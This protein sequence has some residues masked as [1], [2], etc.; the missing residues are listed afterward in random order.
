MYIGDEIPHGHHVY[1]KHRI[2]S[3]SMHV[4]YRTLLEHMPQKVKKH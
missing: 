4:G 1:Y 2:P 3:I